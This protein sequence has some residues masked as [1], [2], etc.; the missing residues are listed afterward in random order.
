MGV[1]SIEMVHEQRRGPETEPWGPSAFQVREMRKSETIPGLP[2][3]FGVVIPCSGGWLY[4]LYRVGHTI[5]KGTAMFTE[6]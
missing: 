5:S 2:F 3:L 6:W 1:I 4:S